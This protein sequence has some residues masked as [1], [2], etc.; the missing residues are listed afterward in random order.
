MSDHRLNPL[1]WPLTVKLPLLVAGL[2]VLVAVVA[3][4]IV[5]VR[6]SQTQ[7]TNLRQ[8]T[9]AYLD[10]LS[11]AVTPHVIRNDIWETYDI[12]DRARELY[13]G[14]R[15]FYTI[16]VLNDGSILAASDPR[17]FPVLSPLPAE[18]A[19]RFAKGQ[20]L[21]IDD[22]GGSAWAYRALK[23]GDLELGR[24]FTKIDITDLISERHV[25][26]LMLVGANIVIT[27]GFVAI[28]YWA[29]RRMVRPVSLL[30]TYV[31]RAR[32]G[33]AELIPSEHMPPP[34][35]EFGTLF[36][37]FNAMARA[38]TERESLAARLA[39]EEKMAQL[40]K[41]A[42]GMAHEVN[43]PLGGMLNVVDTLEKHGDNLQVRKA[44]LEL[45]K[46]GLAGIRNVV[47]ATLLTYKGGAEQHRLNRGDL[48]D[49]QYLVQHEV[50]RRQLRL[51]WESR[52]PNE[53]AVDSAAT[54]QAALNLLLNACAASP[55]G[56]TV[57][58]E[59]RVADSLLHLSVADQGPG[60]PDSVAALL[61][62]PSAGSV[63]PQGKSGLGAWTVA[64]LVAQL[65]GHVDVTSSPD[66]STCINLVIPIGPQGSFHVAA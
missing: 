27:L 52:L 28:G 49:L 3:S 2:I 24:V 23:E 29:A 22:A 56:G 17:A 36:R 18:L 61:A 37:R 6:L 9:G 65:N 55:T 57:R 41:L 4:N 34:A 63:P 1:T 11:T 12:L 20:H 10:G 31:E 46:R 26:L 51:I 8:L 7:E 44:S 32:E 33:Q 16:V 48:D 13:E 53:L 42:S 25:A 30:S 40:G 50:S 5:L 64:R 15:P 35:T 45:L 54:R 58:F 62:T 47:R 66:W 43:N 59:A 39:E 14:V 60:L 19:G 21:V 38:V